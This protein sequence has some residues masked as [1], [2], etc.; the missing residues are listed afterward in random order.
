MK[1]STTLM[2]K[3]VKLP[4]SHPDLPVDALAKFKSEY[5]LPKDHLYFSA[6]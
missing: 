5:F 2:R 6:H 1:Q 3:I 4:A